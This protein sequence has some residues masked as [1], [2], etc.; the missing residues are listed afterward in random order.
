M[1]SKGQLTAATRIVCSQHSVS[2]FASGDQP[3]T[4]KNDLTLPRVYDQE[5]GLLL[6]RREPGQQGSQPLATRPCS[7]TALRD[8]DREIAALSPPEIWEERIW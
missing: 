5:R 2:P 3:T 1:D 7:W 8:A 4:G 6:Q